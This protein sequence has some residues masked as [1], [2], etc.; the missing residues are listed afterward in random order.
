MSASM[1]GMVAHIEGEC[2]QQRML[3]A[4][5]LDEQVGDEH[6]VRVIDALVD[7]LDL[8]ELGFSKVTAEATGRPPY[9]P[10]DLL[11]LYVYGYM[12]Q[13]RSSRRLEREAVRNLEVLWLIR[14][15]APSFKTIADFRRDH[16]AAIVGVCRAFMRFC[17]AQSL[18]GSELLAIDGT[19]IA[20]V[21]SRKKVITAKSLDQ[22]LSALDAKIAEYL[23][24][25]DAADRTEA[26][27]AEPGDVT[28]ALA[29]LQA[30]RAAVQ[31]Q[32][33]ALAADGLAQR[34]VGEPEAKLM[35]VAGHGHQ[36]ADNAQTA[37]DAKHGLIAAFELTNNGNDHQLLLPMAVQ[38]KQAVLAEQLT[39]VADSGYAN[40]EQ[41]QACAAAGITAVVPR[42]RTANP[43]ANPKDDGF[44]SRDAFAYDADSDSWTCPA[45]HILVCRTRSA[46]VPIKQYAT[47][48]CA[49]CAL[50]PQC[51]KSAGRVI[52]R[53]RY[54]D[55]RQAM[56]Q[57]TLDNP[58]WMRRRRELAE[59]P[60]GVIKW[61]MGR[62][63]FLVRGLQKARAELAFS[64]L[65]FNLKRAI[66]IRGI[67]AL[68]AALRA[69]A[70]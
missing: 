6:P 15:L 44:F 8:A 11:K 25:M 60:F 28:A 50:K 19:K 47:T 68:L 29:A 56:H 9:Q 38:G 59:H 13:L 40:G 7:S 66:A 20:A 43:A 31:D 26:S 22:Q 5:S 23:A 70:A 24:A 12:N 69:A 4:P 1:E 3:F 21:A 51:T 36:V 35:R 17:R 18:Y 34:V 42:P 16:P 57:R 33:K 53:D 2:R 58:L 61:M 64:V 14:R 10:G 37:V 49:D 27:P 55:A 30:K 39:V 63:R 54:E 48:A 41:G 52:T 65:G 45:G 62:P 46:A 32:A 67:P